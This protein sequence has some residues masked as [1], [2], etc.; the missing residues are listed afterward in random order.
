MN[1][2]IGYYMEN[3]PKLIFGNQPIEIKDGETVK[4]YRK[5]DSSVIIAET[6][7]NKYIVEPVNNGMKKLV[8]SMRGDNYPYKFVS[9]GEKV[10]IDIMNDVTND[11]AILGLKDKIQ[12][13]SNV[14]VSKNSD[15][16]IGE[17]NISFKFSIEIPNE[18]ED[19]S[20]STDKDTEFNFNK[21]VE[22]SQ[23]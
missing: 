2:L 18:S 19:E 15:I 20:K 6:L 7:Q 13:E 1:P 23:K 12:Y 22:N 10:Y 8:S 5:K 16:V 17:G 4:M 3:V 21:T 11:V 14:P 9:D